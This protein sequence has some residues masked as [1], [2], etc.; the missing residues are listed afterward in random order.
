MKKALS[1]VM[2]FLMLFGLC[3]VPAVSAAGDGSA[4]NPYYVA[5]PNAVPNYVTIPANG[6]VYYQYKAAVFG[7]WSVTGYGLTSIVVDG[8]VYDELN[9]WGEIEA[10]FDFKFISP[11][12][13]AYVND[14]AEEVQVMIT[15]N[16]PLGTENNPDSLADGANAL[17]IPANNANYVADYIPTAN[18]EYTFECA[19][20]ED[21]I[22]SIDVDGSSYTLDKSLTLELESYIPVRFYISPVGVTGE[23]EIFVTPPKA[24]TASNPIWVSTDELA[25]TYVIGAGEDLYFSVDG[26]F[27]GNTLII[28]SV[29][30]ADFTAQVEGVEYASEG[31]VLT[32]VLDSSNWYIE[33]VLSSAVANEFAFTMDYAPGSVENPFLLEDGDNAVSIP[34]G[35]GGYYYSYVVESDGLLVI[36]P[37]SVEGISYLAMADSDYADFAYL[38]EGVSSMMMPVTA[39]ETILV[40]VYTAMDEDTFEYLP[41]DTVLTVAT[42]ELV[43]FNTFEDG[44]LGGWTSSAALSVDDVEYISGWSSAKFEATKDWANMYTYINV[45]KNTDYVISLK[46]KAANNSG[47]WF[48]FHKADWSGDVAKA[49][50][51]LTTE[52]ADYEVTLNSGDNTTLV[53]LLQYA[54]YAADGQIIWV[55]D[56]VITKMASEEPPVL[57]G[58]VDGNGKL[59]NRDLGLMQLY[60]NDGDMTDKAF[61]EAAADLDGNGKI[62]NR[63]LGLLQK[64]L[65]K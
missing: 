32:C 52:W 6:A 30:G 63:D 23:V 42:K 26:S 21:F 3:V 47:S 4:E 20:T 59:N 24:G 51:A 53:V 58:D 12:I 34:A 8:V 55:D 40:E 50:L 54:G 13:V 2:V 1:L 56:L 49:D 37:A 45:E 43:L 11:G 15:H 57:M 48:K 16:Q 22:I 46:A 33:L 19:Q 35:K 27:S 31:G 10:P 7:G 36:T 5:N 25:A 65:N 38:Q 44:N 41:L 64:E 60:L 17:S 39:G 9:P 28:E 61:D 29:S 18:G 62:N 14:T